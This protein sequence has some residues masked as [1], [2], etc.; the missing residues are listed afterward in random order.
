MPLNITFLGSGIKCWEVVKTKVL[1]MPWEHFLWVCTEAVCMAIFITILKHNYHQ[2][3]QK[4]VKVW[5]FKVSIWIAASVRHI[6]SRLVIVYCFSRIGQI[7]ERDRWG[8]VCTLG[9]AWWVLHTESDTSF[10]CLHQSKLQLMVWESKFSLY[11]PL[12][13]L[14]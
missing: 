9:Q 3:C 12:G 6:S 5:A 2:I 1:D 13:K 11:F 8:F 7:Q 10:S 4:S 14:Q